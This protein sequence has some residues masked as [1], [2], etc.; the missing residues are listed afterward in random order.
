[1]MKI[2][3]FSIFVEDQDIAQE[4]YTDRLG[5]ELKHNI[6]M[7]GPKWLTVVEK[8]SNNPVEIVLEPNDNP[9]AREYQEKLYNSNIPV[10][11]FGVDDIEET[12][13]HL[14]SKG[15]E[16]KTK[17]KQVED[18]KLAVFDDQ[19]GNLLQIIEN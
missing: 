8:N 4:V 12:Y 1:M 17:P 13:T 14:K 6:D 7:G 3:A 10:T 19:C 18:M 9:I 15:I 2:I 11:M 16:F 5:F